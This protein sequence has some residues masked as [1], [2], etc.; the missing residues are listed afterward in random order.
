MRARRT[1]HSKLVGWLA[2]AGLAVIAASLRSQT[3][4][5]LAAVVEPSRTLEILPLTDGVYQW[6]LMD[7]QPAG[8]GAVHR[9]RRVQFDRADL[10]DLRVLPGLSNGDV[11][12]AGQSLV[13]LQSAGITH[14]I[15]GLGAQRDSLMAQRALLAAGGTDAE[16]REARQALRLA[17]TM[18]Q[19]EQP[20]LER[21]RQLAAAGAIS[22][23]ELQ[24]AELL[25]EV[26]QVEIR[27]AR[28]RIDVVQS[29]ARPEALTAIDA[30]IE[31]LD[32]RLQS[33][34]VLNDPELF[35]SPISGVVE[36]GAGALL[37]VR[38]LDV[39]YVRVPW[40]ERL[41]SQIGLGTSMEFRGTASPAVVHQGRVV[42]I[43][44]EVSVFGLEPVFWVSAKVTNTS[45][46]LRGGMTGHAAVSTGWGPLAWWSGEEHP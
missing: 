32:A 14:A 33:L 24:A 18:A 17:T 22:V 2:L 4:I 46:T 1:P 7:G 37:R 42:D 23:A 29:S 31:A 21:A 26:R 9:Q 40:P 39:V 36:L 25:G 30:E 41:R 27:L 6:T 16:V 44:D 38:D 15:D 34:E 5:S 13:E 28:S 8:G 43:S 12:E 35:E 45:H 19:G 10:I 20:E 11:I 3:G